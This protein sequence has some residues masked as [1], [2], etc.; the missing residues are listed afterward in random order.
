MNRIGGTLVEMLVTLVIL[1]IIASVTTL[2]IRRTTPPNPDDPMTI[3]ADTV[4][5]VLRS[6]RPATLQF[7]VNGRPALATIKPDGSVISDTA[8]HIDQFTGGST[9]A[10]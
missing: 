9:R 1:G 4:N 3:I 10:R 6:G 5:E 8:L 2:A 7:T